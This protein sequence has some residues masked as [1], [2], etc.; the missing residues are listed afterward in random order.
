M[1]KAFVFGMFGIIGVGLFLLLI[2]GCISL[3]AW[4]ADLLRTYRSG[5]R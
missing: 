2:F 1:G 3:W 5:R 4:G